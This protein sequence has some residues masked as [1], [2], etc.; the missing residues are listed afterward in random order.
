MSRQDRMT[1]RANCVVVVY[2]RYREFIRDYRILRR[3]RR[4]DSI[5]LAR[6]K[7]GKKRDTPRTFRLSVSLSLSFSLEFVQTVII[8][9]HFRHA[10]VHMRAHTH[11]HTRELLT[12]FAKR[13][14]D[15]LLTRSRVIHGNVRRI[16]NVASEIKRR[17]RHAGIPLSRQR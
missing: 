9:A 3:Q 10:H 11:T 16:S 13:L 2:S 5:M 8:K 1:K 15:F 6:E 17:E 7:R 12:K 4:D 14:I